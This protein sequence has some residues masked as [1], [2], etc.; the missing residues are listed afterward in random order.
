MVNQNYMLALFSSLLNINA[1]VISS[2][3]RI[4]H[5][6]RCREEDFGH[7]KGFSESLADFIVVQENGV[8]MAEGTDLK[9]TLYYTAGDSVFQCF[10][11]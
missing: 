1:H 5:I 10:S 7:A 3:D 2:T 8:T 9:F 4:Q 6:L 11:R